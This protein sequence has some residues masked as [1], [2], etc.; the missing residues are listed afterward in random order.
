MEKKYHSFELFNSLEQAK[1]LEALLIQNGINCLIK[2]NASTFNAALGTTSQQECEVFVLET[3][4]ERAKNIIEENVEKQVLVAKDDHYLYEFT[5][6]EL[7]EILL[8]KEEWSDFDVKLADKILTERGVED[9]D[10]LH[11]S[12]I[13]QKR[14]EFSKPEKSK[15]YLL[16]FG[17]FFALFGGI[18]GGPIGGYLYYSYNKLPN[19]EEIYKFST[20]DRNHGKRIMTIGVITSIIW[21]IVK[22]N[23]RV[24]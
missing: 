20:R 3:D 13:E 19:G 1:E 23:P 5:N 24:K 4:L 14:E 2:D 10:E 18:L 16:F 6:Q 15:F 17:Y 7:Y 22:L 9:T 8:K 21:I 12:L 11:K